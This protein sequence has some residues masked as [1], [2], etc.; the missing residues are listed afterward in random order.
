MSI[1]GVGSSTSLLVQSLVDMR[2]KLDDLQ[3]QLGTGQ[4]ST[5]YA[6]LGLGRG[7][8]VGL[9]FAIVGAVG[10]R[11]H[12]DQCRHPAFPRA[13]RAHPACRH[14][15]GRERLDE[16]FGIACIQRKRADDRAEHGA[17]AARPVARRAQHAG[18]RPL[19]VLRARRRSAD[20][21]HHGSHPQRQ[22]HARRLQAGPVRAQPGRSRRERARAAGD[23]GRVGQQRVDRRGCRRLAVRVQARRRHLDHRRR[24]GQRPERLAG[25]HIGQSFRR[26]A[27]RRRHGQVHL[28][29][30]GRHD[31]GPDADGDRVDD[32]GGE[33]VHHRRHAR[34]DRR[35][36]AGGAD[37]RGRSSSPARRCRP[38]PRSR[39]RTTSS[40]STPPIRRGASPAR[41]SPPRPRWSPARRPTR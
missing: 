1:T 31:P 21:R 24:D 8:A 20:D 15:P 11:R 3:T 30:A 27:E 12:D 16:F 14:R 4:K 17:D 34:G 7:L 28:Q 41:R 9:Q 22:R 39:R 10:L 6:G 38:P 37:E 35:Q 33:P 32:A 36:P 19:P 29:P 26:D 5:T 13:D 2:S 40:T 18:R 23:S 25:R